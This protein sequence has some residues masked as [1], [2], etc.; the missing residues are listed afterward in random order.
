VFL[1]RTVPD[2]DSL[3]TEQS[4]GSFQT[5]PRT[6]TLVALCL[7][8]PLCHGI[9]RANC[10]SDPLLCHAINRANCSPDQ[11]IY[12]SESRRGDFLVLPPQS[13]PRGSREN[14]Y[15]MDASKPAIFF[16]STRHEQSSTAH[17]SSRVVCIV[18]VDAGQAG[19]GL[20]SS[21]ANTSASGASSSAGADLETPSRG[22]NY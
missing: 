1:G 8:P 7:Y 21:N 3:D 5:T 22:A 19:Y 16:A 4:L 13:I 20:C 12:G 14:M 6:T 15:E 10:S 17:S 18:L 2:H 11:V 9:N